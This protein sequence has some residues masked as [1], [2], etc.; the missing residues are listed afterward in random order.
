MFKIPTWRQAKAMLFGSDRPGHLFAAVVAGSAIAVAGAITMDSWL[1]QVGLLVPAWEWACTPDVDLA[2]Q[3]NRRRGSIFWRLICW[4]WWPYGVAVGHRSKLSHS[5]MFGLPCRLAYVA[6][7][8]ALIG[9]LGIVGPWE[10]L[11][12][13]VAQLWNHGHIQAAIAHLA[14]RLSMV[15]LAATIGDTVHMVKDNYSIQEIIW[16]K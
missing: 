1:V 8:I 5:L 15:L 14:G 10:F 4:L 7:A 12:G 16:G 9:Y 11:V 2:N 6:A 3:R 13:D